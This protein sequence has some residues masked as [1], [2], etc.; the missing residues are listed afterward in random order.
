MWYIYIT[1]YHSSTKRYAIL[2]YA[3]TWVSI[4]NILLSERSQTYK[5]AYCMIPLY[6]RSRKGKP[7]VT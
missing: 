5:I 6:E 4:K 2:I 1:K 3:R 7:R